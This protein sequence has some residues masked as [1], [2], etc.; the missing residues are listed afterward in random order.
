[1]SPSN[2]SLSIPD[3]F[4]TSSH[5]KS[6][7]WGCPVNDIVKAGSKAAAVKEIENECQREI[8]K[9]VQ[10]TPNTKSV[11]SIKT[12]WPDLQI[13]ENAGEYHMTGTIFFETLAMH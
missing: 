4:L 7:E 3:Q 1:M 11:I 12:I 9:A 13:R 5:T 10:N 6:A 2:P 8:L